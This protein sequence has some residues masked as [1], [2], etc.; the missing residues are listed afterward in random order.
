MTSERSNNDNRDYVLGVDSDEL[1]RLGFQHHI[2]GAETA[3]LWRRAGV[4]TG[5]TILDLGAGPGFASIELARLVTPA[6]RVVAIDKA[7]PYLDHLDRQQAAG[8][9]SGN[10]QTICAE[11]GAFDIEAV[12]IDVAFARWL[13]CFT[14]EPG[15]VVERVAR[16]LKPG[17]VF[18][19]M[20]YY[21]YLLHGFHERTVVFERVIAAASK[22]FEA[23]G[24]EANIGN[25]LPALL[26]E[27]GLVVRD[28]RPLVKI[29]TPGSMLWN[30]PHSFWKLFTPKLASMGMITQQDCDD[31]LKEW[32]MRSRQPGAFFSTPPMVQIVAVK[33][34]T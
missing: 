27:A 10:I 4:A 5:Q 17:G 14:P 16:A 2:W 20:D 12:S 8:A 1:A 19:V 25:R 11:A 9:T 7:Q 29:A 18:A 32:D 30:W 21:N 33:P 28:I 31:Y 23:Q 13:M 24:G 3:A 15:S 22:S 34:T 6:G 26:L